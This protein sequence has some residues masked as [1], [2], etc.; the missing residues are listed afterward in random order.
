MN[1]ELA[2]VRVKS[3]RSQG[4]GCAKQGEPIVPHLKPEESFLFQAHA[5]AECYVKLGDL[6]ASRDP[7]IFHDTDRVL[8]QSGKFMA[9]NGV[10]I[11]RGQGTLIS[12]F[13][14]FLVL[15]FEWKKN[16]IGDFDK[17]DLSGSEAVANANAAVRT[18]TYPGN[19]QALRHFRNALSHG[20]IGWE[21]N[22]ELVVEDRDDRKGYAYIAEYSMDSLGK[23]AQSLNMAI[24][25]YIE[26]VIKQRP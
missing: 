1:A 18:D 15:P 10:P 14:M 22:G 19:D 9:S 17:F 13:Y 5:L 6:E 26:T 12:V 8:G 3:R 23:L 24:A 4:A 7:L 2:D 11:F 16:K 20:R 25:N 21:V